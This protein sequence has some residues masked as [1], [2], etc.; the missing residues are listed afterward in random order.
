MKVTALQIWLFLHVVG[1]AV[2]IGGM[3]FAHFCLRPSVA[4]LQP[5]MRAPLM[6]AAL[7]R[8]FDLV[9]VSLVL[10]WASGL[11]M[12]MDVGFASA[13]IGWHVMMGIAAV[14]TLV[15]AVIR[16]RH[17]PA[18]RRA[19]TVVDLPAA[20][21]ALDAIRRL[22]MLNLGL[23]IAVIAVATLIG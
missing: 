2:W 16:T 21:L 7:G 22:V 4:D 17:Y 23:G 9:T 1:V 11:A 6:V 20:A 8:F 12:L 13:P 5:A 10:I 14:M 3:V 18:A 15:F 19:V